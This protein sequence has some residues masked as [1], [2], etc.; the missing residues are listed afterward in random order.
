MVEHARILSRAA[1]AA[2]RVLDAWA[3]HRSAGARA[4]RE[5][6]RRDTHRARHRV[7]ELDAMHRLAE[8]FDRTGLPQRNRLE[9]EQA[10]SMIDRSGLVRPVF[11]RR[12]SRSA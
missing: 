4:G 11:R 7:K 6:M 10:Q 9:A 2:Y 3:L 12:R 5:R 8:A 1:L